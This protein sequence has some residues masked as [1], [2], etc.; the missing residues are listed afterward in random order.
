MS[1]SISTRQSPTAE[2]VFCNMK[3]APKTHIRLAAGLAAVLLCGMTAAL[4][5]AAADPAS[6][7]YTG[8]DPQE[9]T[10]LF[11][12]F[13]GI[14]H[15]SLRTVTGSALPFDTA[16]AD[17]QL[18]LRMAG[19][20]LSQTAEMQAN[21]TILL[22]N[23]DDPDTLL[24]F[25][26][27]YTPENTGKYY[28]AGDLTQDGNISNYDTMLL[29]KYLLGTYAINPVQGALSD[30]NGDGTVNAVD[31][32]LAKRQRLQNPTAAPRSVMLNVPEYS[33]HPEYPT[34]CES[35][36]L[37]IL[38]QYYHTA[39]T[40]D[41]IIDALPKGPLPYYVGD[42]MYG[43]NPEKEFVGDPRTNYSYGVFNGPIAQTA[44]LFRSG[45]RTQTQVPLEDIFPILDTGN[46]VVAW[47]TTT[48]D[49]DIFYRRSWYDYETGE[50]IRWPGGEHAVVIC[51][52]DLG[53]GTLTYRDP[54]TGGSNTLP[55]EKFR[56]IYDEL[57]GRI[58]YYQ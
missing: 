36:A 35:I 46:P 58:V 42:V 27:A 33:Q 4:P 17:T 23:A 2:R 21:G 47:Y 37:Y 26:Q 53:A 29:Q 13:D 19:S 15:G 25:V 38:L 52:Y 44:A 20:D 31:L 12:L 51:G 9:G 1:G 43:A 8:F 45:V 54:N 56:K 14:G 6:G 7:I 22:H 50:L 40:P 34:G 24:T 49:R 57:G 5:A 32:T 30:L 18:T 39:V 3:R 11:Y 48:P 16:Q 28:L 41:E 10:R 55:I